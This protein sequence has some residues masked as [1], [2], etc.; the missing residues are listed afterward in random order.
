MTNPESTDNAT[1]G[2]PA[3]SNYLSALAGEVAAEFALYKSTSTAAHRAYLSVGTKLLEAR[4]ATRHGQW[5]VFLKASGLEGRTARNMMTLARAGLSADEVT[6]AGGV[7]A[8]LELLRQAA[9][10]VLGSDGELSPA[11]RHAEARREARKHLRDCVVR[12][13]GYCAICQRLLPGDLTGV[14]VDHQRPLADRGTSESANLQATH[15]MCNLVKGARVL[16]PADG[17]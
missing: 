3:L 2:A 8:A 5:A 17:A 16:F 6:A 7:R 15:A 10:A 13:R 1:E 14:H 12:Q 9:K 11:A 4:Q